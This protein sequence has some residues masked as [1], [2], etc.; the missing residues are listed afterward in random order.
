MKIPWSWEEFQQQKRRRRRKKKR[1]KKKKKIINSWDYLSSRRMPYCLRGCLI[2]HTRSYINICVLFRGEPV[3]E[4]DYVGSKSSKKEKK[5]TM[6][7]DSNVFEISFINF[8]PLLPPPPLPKSQDTAEQKRRE[9]I[10]A[11]MFMNEA[12]CWWCWPYNNMVSFVRLPLLLS[13]D[14]YRWLSLIIVVDVLG[15]DRMFTLG[16]IS[17]LAH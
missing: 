16:Q 13:R 6:N 9:R 14:D 15:S 7:V 17:T 5:T 3:I 4:D 12:Q 11:L 2:Q 1:T 10:G 8:F